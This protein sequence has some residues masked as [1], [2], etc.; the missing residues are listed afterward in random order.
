MWKRTL[1]SLGLL[2]V[3]GGPALAGRTGEVSASTR[4]KTA[5]PSLK[6]RVRLNRAVY[7]LVGQQ[8]SVARACG[9]DGAASVRARSNGWDALFSFVTVGL[10]T[11]QHA[12]IVCNP[13]ARG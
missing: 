4:W 13:P 9:P 7:N 2:A 8:P 10:Y 11:P 3:V 1:L 12:Y 5:D 6:R